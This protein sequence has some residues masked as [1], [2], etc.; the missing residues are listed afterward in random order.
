MANRFWV[1][2]AVTGAASGTGGVVRLTV[3]AGLAT[4]K[5]TGET[6][7]VAG[8]V[9]TVEANGTWVITAV[10]S[11]HIELQGS[12]FAIAYVS[13]GTIA[14]G[15]WNATNIGNWGTASATG[16][17]ATVPGSSDAVTFDAVSGS[18]VVNTT[19]GVQSI[20][21]GAHVGTL[22]FSANNN[23]VALSG[24]TGLS[25]TGTG[26]RTLN[27]GNGTWS[28]AGGAGGT[29]WNFATI[30]NLTFNANSSVLSFSGVLAAGRSIT[31]GAGLTY[32]TIT[33]GANA[34]GGAYD[35]GSATNTVATFNIT[36]PNTVRFGNGI[37]LTITNAISWVGSSA[38]QINLLAALNTTSTISSA[39]SGTLAWC[40]IRDLT[41][42][43]GG[44]FT[45]QNSF[46]LGH[47]SGVTITPPTMTRSRGWSEF[48]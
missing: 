16:S 6:V 35:F 26:V 44:T 45:A 8:V 41:F 47:N 18:C 38:S 4:G 29:P 25:A 13:G 22:D 14:G 11:T 23:N 27:L 46:N 12:T 17:G 48:A 40:G 2:V 32:S 36:A 3:G 1:A 9:G 34:S 21:C 24:Q 20:T 39:N 31:L 28:I 15:T 19:V 42:A 33:L 7:V 5:V 10:D 30:T 43:G 37:T